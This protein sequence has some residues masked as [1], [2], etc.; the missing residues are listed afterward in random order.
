MMKRTLAAALL[1]AALAASAAVPA[2]AAERTVPVQ[3]D[4]AELET[5]N[6]LENGVTYVP[7]RALLDAFGGW[8]LHWD[9]AKR[10]AAASSG[11][12]RL[13]ADPAA[14]SITVNGIPYAGRVTVRGGRTYVPLRLTANLCGAGV[15]W[16]GTLGG[17]AVTSPEAE[18]DAEELYWLSRIIYA[19]SGAESMTGQIAVGNVILNRMESS[20]F[21]NTVEGVI[22]D[23]KDAVQFE[24]VSNG[25]IYKTPSAQSVEA[26][27][28]VLD[29]ENVIGS[30]LYFYA[31][32]LSQGVWINA[33][34]T[35][36]QTIGCHRFYL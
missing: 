27:R 18:Y 35:Y 1:T 10:Q 2:A 20:R 7:L 28:R 22:F 16:D 13:T 25:Q 15:A 17:A 36:Q 19:E 32:A 26:A 11:T 34:C 9:S 12:M 29:G 8:E 33:S 30:A 4:G 3:V 31:P 14:D 21:P 24:P 5:V 6:Y 23:R